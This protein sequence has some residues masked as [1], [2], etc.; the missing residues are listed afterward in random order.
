MQQLRL[1]NLHLLVISSC[2]GLKGGLDGVTQHAL[3]L[4]HPRYH[5]AAEVYPDAAL[6]APGAEVAPK[7][8]EHLH[9]V[10]RT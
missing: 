8:L 1:Y 9:L 7:G 4:I 2:S 6:L 10:R 5:A 3:Q